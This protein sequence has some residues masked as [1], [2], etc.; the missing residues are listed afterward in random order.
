MTR[1]KSRKLFGKFR[2]DLRKIDLQFLGFWLLI[3]S[4]KELVPQNLEAIP[5]F[6]DFFQAIDFTHR[7]KR[8]K[9]LLTYGL[10]KEITITTI[11]MFYKDT[12]AM[13]YSRDSDTDFFHNVARIFQGDTLAPFIF[14]ICP[15]Y[16]RQTSI[17]RIKGNG[18]TLKKGI[19]RQYPQKLWQIPTSRMID[20]F[21][22]IHLFKTN[23]C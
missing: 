1:L 19:S 8:E 13:V 5:L 6:V 10:P 14:I 4:L 22:Q 15:D 23:L 20:S 3:E 9:I 11:L 18:F 17:D 16:I 21:S 2:T 12:K 7:G